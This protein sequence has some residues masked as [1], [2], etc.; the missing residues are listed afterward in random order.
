GVRLVML[1]EEHLAREPVELPPDLAAREELLAQPHRHR[2]GELPQAA[3]RHA[4]I[5]L[6]QALELEE[7]LVVE[8]DVVARVEREPPPL[9][10]VADGVRGEAGVVSLAREALLLRG[11]DDLAVAHQARRRIVIE[12][13]EAQNRGHQVVAIRTSGGSAPDR[14]AR[15]DASPTPMGVRP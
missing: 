10:A 1:G 4:E 12:G 5:L 3:R 6:E 11:R 8:A 14:P 13:G 2:G 9:Q 7:W 15:G